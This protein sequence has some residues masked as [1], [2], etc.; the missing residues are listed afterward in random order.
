LETLK[1]LFNFSV[2][3]IHA[4]V[5]FF[6]NSTLLIRGIEKW[7]YGNSRE[8]GKKMICFLHQRQALPLQLQENILSMVAIKRLHRS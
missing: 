8:T 5:T 7:K 6:S 4:F 3:K 2:F 1:T